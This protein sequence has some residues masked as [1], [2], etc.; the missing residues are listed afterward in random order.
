M[1]D[2]WQDPCEYLT[3]DD[4]GQRIADLEQR[5]ERLEAEND[6]LMRERLNKADKGAEVIVSLQAQVERLE[7]EK[8]QLIKQH[9]NTIKEQCDAVGKMRATLAEKKKEI[10][11]RVGMHP[12][13]V[14][15][16]KKVRAELATEKSLHEDACQ[17]QIDLQARSARLREALE[18]I[19][20]TVQ[21]YDL[22]QAD[23][24]V[25]IRMISGQA[26]R[27]QGES[28]NAD[29]AGECFGL[30]DDCNR[31]LQIGWSREELE[32]WFEGTHGYRFS[33]AEQS[34]GF[35]CQQFTLNPT[36]EER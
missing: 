21:D 17:I 34:K 6:R 26:L 33:V 12:G 4:D 30:L 5:C 16:L 10:D 11:Y 14:S 27:E 25:A 9:K 36:T 24:L 3:P 18:L 22:S 32:D 29:S 13:L 20:K 8:A 28:S 23:R 15:E 35:V 1:S 7:A 2:N 19:Q 31:I